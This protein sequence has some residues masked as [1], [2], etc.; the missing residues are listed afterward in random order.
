MMVETQSLQ[1]SSFELEKGG[2]MEKKN[3][4]PQANLKPKNNPQPK[5]FLWGKTDVIMQLNNSEI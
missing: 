3:P 2:Q 4:K 1:V 5:N